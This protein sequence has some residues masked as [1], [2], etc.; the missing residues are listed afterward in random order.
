MAALPARLFDSDRT[1]VEPQVV[2]WGSDIVVACGV[3]R[4]AD[5]SAVSRCDVVNDIGW[6]AEQ[7]SGGWRFTTIERPVYVQVIVGEAH[8]P[9]ADA[10]VDVADAVAKMPATK[11]CV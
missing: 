8:S 6:F 11:P 7:T 3:D 1:L 4:P 5:V 10:L 9:A 2:R